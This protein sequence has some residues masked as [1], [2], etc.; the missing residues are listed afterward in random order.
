MMLLTNSGVPLNPTS[1]T[2]SKLNQEKELFFGELYCSLIHF[3]E[4][5]CIHPDHH[6]FKVQKITERKLN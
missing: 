4:L 6:L 1:N 3:V 2:S 5:S